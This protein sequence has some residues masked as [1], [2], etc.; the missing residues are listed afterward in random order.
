MPLSYADSAKAQSTG[1]FDLCV[2]FRS[3]I[4]LSDLVVEDRE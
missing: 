3:E 4:Q 2:Y 1:E